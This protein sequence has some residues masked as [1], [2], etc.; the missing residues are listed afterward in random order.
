MPPGEPRLIATRFPQRKDR[1]GCAGCLPQACIEPGGAE[2][3]R[4]LMAAVLGLA[5][6]WAGLAAAQQS[7]TAGDD[8]GMATHPQ[9][10]PVHEAQQTVPGPTP[11]ETSKPTDSDKFATGKDQGRAQEGSGSSEAK[12][13]GAAK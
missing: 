2:M 11:Q 9:R 3:K 12:K 1:F 4:V 8:K 13:D 10:K 6:G 7:P 5:T